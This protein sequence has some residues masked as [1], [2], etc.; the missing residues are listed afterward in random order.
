LYYFANYESGPKNGVS[1]IVLGYTL[2]VLID[3]AH[4]KRLAGK[5]NKALEQ[6]HNNNQM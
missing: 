6:F 2:V 4:S 5:F 3:N 1:S